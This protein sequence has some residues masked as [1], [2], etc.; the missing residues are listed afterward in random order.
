MAY[1]GILLRGEAAFNTLYND[2]PIAREVAIGAEHLGIGSL[3]STVYWLN[4]QALSTRLPNSSIRSLSSPKKL[5][6]MTVDSICTS[7]PS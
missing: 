4:L 3:S 6:S 2:P 7:L 5:Q 1:T